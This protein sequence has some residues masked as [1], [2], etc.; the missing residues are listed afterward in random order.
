MKLIYEI[1]DKADKVT[2]HECEDFASFGGDFITLFKKGF[3]RE[4]IRTETV[5]HVR[6]YIK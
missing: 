3:V 1:T 2:R 6:S 5:L 4:H